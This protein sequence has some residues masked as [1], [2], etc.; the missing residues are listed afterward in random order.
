M[1]YTATGLPVRKTDDS[2][3]LPPPTTEGEAVLLLPLPIDLLIS[4][5]DDLS[6]F[7]LCPIFV[8]HFS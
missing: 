2:T 7:A 3:T 6:G 8:P 1:V 4:H 5:P